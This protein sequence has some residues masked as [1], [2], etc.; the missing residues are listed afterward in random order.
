[1]WYLGGGISFWTTAFILA[2][3][4]AVSANTNPTERPVLE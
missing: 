1:M 3:G 2:A 4:S